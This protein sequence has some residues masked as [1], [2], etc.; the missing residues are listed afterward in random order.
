MKVP[1]K[2]N[3]ERAEEA[4]HG[5]MRERRDERVGERAGERLLR[6]GSVGVIEAEEEALP[7]LEQVDEGEVSA[8]AEEERQR[9]EGFVASFAV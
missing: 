7:E 8:G 9:L 1:T 2:R 5:G 3:P 6:E 4:V